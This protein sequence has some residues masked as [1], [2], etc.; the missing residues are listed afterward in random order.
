MNKI[1]PTYITF[2]QAKWLK[3]KGFDEKVHQYYQFIKNASS[4]LD[5]TWRFI[6]SSFLVRESDAVM[7]PDEGKNG[8]EVSAYSDRIFRDYNFKTSDD[9]ISAPEQ[10]Q[11]V[12]WLR[13]KHNIDVHHVIVAASHYGY[14]IFQNRTRKHKEEGY[15][16]TPKEAYSAAFDHIRLNNL[17]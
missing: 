2:E 7:F 3:E 6:Y 13:L 5:K 14:N 10:Y 8:I 15:F 9:F 16:L 12:E 17:I 1:E 4:K 11:V